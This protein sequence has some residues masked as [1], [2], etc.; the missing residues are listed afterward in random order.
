MDISTLTKLL[1]GNDLLT[2]VSDN[3]GK[4][5]SLGKLKVFSSYIKKILETIGHLINLIYYLTLNCEGLEYLPNSFSQLTQ[6]HGIATPS[7]LMDQLPISIIKRYRDDE[8]WIETYVRLC[9]TKH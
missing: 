6:I 1:I 9:R 8:L 2:E 7:Q 3:I 5:K 4:L